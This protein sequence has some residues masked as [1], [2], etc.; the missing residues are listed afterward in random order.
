MI[1]WSWLLG[2]WAGSGL[3]SRIVGVVVATYPGMALSEV[4]GAAVVVVVWSSV[5]LTRISTLWMLLV[6]ARRYCVVSLSNSGSGVRSRLRYRPWRL[7]LAWLWRLVI[8][9]LRC[10]RSIALASVASWPCKIS[11][12]AIHWSSKLC[13]S[14]LIKVWVQRSLL[15]LSSISSFRSA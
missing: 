11:F 12:R 2:P 10:C 14:P 7:L 13:R 5:S 8:S 1:S 4:A 3:G 15:N 6:H 9:S